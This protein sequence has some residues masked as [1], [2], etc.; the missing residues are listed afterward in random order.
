MLWVRV[1]PEAIQFPR[2]LR[3]E[4]CREY[5]EPCVTAKVRALCTASSS[6]M[7]D[8]AHQSPIAIRNA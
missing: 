8:Y 2:K 3:W 6:G 4:N 1:T 5:D 7:S